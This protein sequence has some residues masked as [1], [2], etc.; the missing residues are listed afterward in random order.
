MTSEQTYPS[1]FK[2]GLVQMSPKPL[3][4]AYNFSVAVAHIQDAASQGASLVVLPEYHLTSWVPDDPKFASLASKAWDYTLKYQEIAK[5]L[6]INIVPG[7]IVTTDPNSTSNSKAPQ[8]E[9][10]KPDADDFAILEGG[11]ASAPLLFNVAPFISQTGELLGLYTKANL[12]LPEREYL[13]AHPPVSPPASTTTTTTTTTTTGTRPAAR[14]PHNSSSS[15]RHSVIQTPLGPVGILTCW[16]LAFP[17]AFRALIRQ[18]ARMIIIPSFWLN[19]DIPLEARKYSEDTESTFL[20][21]TLVSRAFENTCAVV[22]CN[23]GGPAEEGYIGLSQVAMPLLGVVPGSF[24]G[25]EAG[26][27][28][29]EVDMN[30]V[31]IAET[32]YGVRADLANPDWHYGDG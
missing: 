3:D 16:D 9:I 18:G 1:V 14:E 13:T 12:W 7:T 30:A 6:N 4:P 19:T 25:P 26:M 2:V 8:Q 29:V 17:E 11:S 20:R 21:A 15:S 10:P 31:D 5:D 22:F 28:I 27:R 24:A 32:A 23:A